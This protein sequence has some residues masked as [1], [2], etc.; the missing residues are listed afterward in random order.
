MAVRTRVPATGAGTCPK[1]QEFWTPAPA[2]APARLEG[3][4]YPGTC[5]R[6]SQVSRK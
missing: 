4:G 1:Y 3:G 5:G 2:H 6:Y